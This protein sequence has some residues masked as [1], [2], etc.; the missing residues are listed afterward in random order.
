M[1]KPRLSVVVP[2]HNV[3]DYIDDCLTSLTHQTFDDFEVIL[4]DDGS[5]DASIEIAREFC[6]RDPR[7]RLVTQENQGLGPARNAGARHAEGDY[8]TFADS[9]DLIPRYAYG[10]MVKTLDDSGSSFAAGNARRFNNALGVRP[11]YVHR[12]PFATDRIGTHVFSFHELALDRMVWNKV[13][14]RSFWN[15]HGYEFPAIHYEDY[16]VTLRAHLDAVTVDVLSAPTYYWRERESG[17]SITQRVFEYQN[18][19]ERVVSDEMVLDLVDRRA[20][21]LRSIVHRHFTVIDLA[22][23]LQAFA[24]VGESDAEA[25][26][27]LGR[28][29]IDRLDRGAL[30][31]SSPF[32]QLQQSALRAGNVEMLRRL[33]RMERDGNLVGGPQ[34]RKRRITPWA[35][36]IDLPGSDH[37]GIPGRFYHVPRRRLRLGTTVTDVRWDADAL[38]IS[39][40]AEIRQ[41]RTSERSDLRL[42]LRH[43]TKRYPLDV[44]RTTALDSHGERRPVGFTATIPLTLLAGLEATGVTSFIEVDFTTDGLR[45]VDDLRGAQPGNPTMAVGTWAGDRVWFQPGPA[46]NGRYGIKQL[47]DPFQITA[48]RFT[49]TEL[50]I[51]GRLPSGTAHASLELSRPS[52]S[53][54]SVP[55]EPTA[56]ATEF[57]AV[58]PVDLLTD[59]HGLDDPFTLRSTWAIHAVAAGVATPLTLAGFNR[60]VSRVH[61]D[62]VTVLTRTPAQYGNLVDAPLRLIADTIGIQDGPCLAIGG[63]QWT[64]KADPVVWR[65]F[66]DRADRHVDVEAAL[67]TEN[68]RWSATVDLAD[69]VADLPAMR[70]VVNLGEWAPYAVGRSA[71]AYGIPIDPF[72]VAR[73]PLTIEVAGRI[74]TVTPRAGSFFIEVR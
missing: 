33:A 69:L 62:R 71:S 54:V 16:P 8:I 28:R 65:R 18:L 66:L 44:R 40:T 37:R 58:L 36:E 51:G 13:Y 53:S 57:T 70:S 25:L 22:A 41:V 2:Y 39:G 1:L 11:S 74:V 20:P 38:L 48:A 9:D 50:I 49:G 15:E 6:R 12:I 29:M 47:I 72:A 27:Q 63:E 32:A 23:L 59:P 14:R 61:G 55:L 3:A 52:G 60:P 19:L 10:L 26:A 68:G 64:D 17:E 34:V 43:D 30:G 73:L 5:T 56:D 21:E 24:T 67:S 35:Y 45:R 42:T 4:V 31:R 7:F 46:S